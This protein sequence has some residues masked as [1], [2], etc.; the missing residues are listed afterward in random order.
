MLT[1]NPHRVESKDHGRDYLFT[2]VKNVLGGRSGLL[3]AG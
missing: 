1:S 3:L 2:P